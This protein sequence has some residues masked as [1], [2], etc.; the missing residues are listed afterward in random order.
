METARKGGSGA[1][2]G[3]QGEGNVSNE[4]GGVGEYQG[5]GELFLSTMNFP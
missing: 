2:S 1:A 4:A 3:A 5:C